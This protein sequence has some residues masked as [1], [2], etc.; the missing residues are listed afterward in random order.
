[1]LLV[2]LQPHTRSSE[3][4]ACW[5][6]ADHTNEHREKHLPCS[7]TLR[8]CGW[9]DLASI[10]P[11]MQSSITPQGRRLDSVARSVSAEVLGDAITLLLRDIICGR[12]CDRSAALALA[13]HLLTA[14][15]P[16]SEIVCLTVM[17][18]LVMDGDSRL[19]VPSGLPGRC[20]Y[21]L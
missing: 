6:Q 7:A 15:A 12:A 16:R 21:S 19:S 11:A 10:S 5:K 1:M 2:R 20:N 17:T 8:I 18:M 9:H 4:L 14:F 3:S 13:Y